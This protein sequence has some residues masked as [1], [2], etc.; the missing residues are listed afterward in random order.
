MAPSLFILALLLTVAATDAATITVVNK[1]SYTVWPAAIPGI[2]P[3]TYS[4]A[5]DDKSSTFTCAAGT[6][7]KVTFCP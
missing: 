7:Y 1:C 2:C 6:N 3:D 4:Y 5:Y